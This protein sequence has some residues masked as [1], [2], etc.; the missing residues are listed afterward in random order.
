MERNA[1]LSGLALALA[2]CCEDP[3]FSSPT[4]NHSFF[5]P[6]PFAVFPF[7]CFFCLTKSSKTFRYE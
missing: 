3:H 5:H 7:V 2:G 4:F 6:Q 1:R